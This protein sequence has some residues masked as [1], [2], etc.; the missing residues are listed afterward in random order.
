MGWQ[1]LTIKTVRSLYE[2]SIE[3]NPWLP[4][5]VL[6]QELRPTSQHGR[7]RADPHGRTSVQVQALQRGVPAADEEEP[8][9]ADLQ[10]QGHRLQQY[11]LGCHPCTIDTLL[12]ELWDCFSYEAVLNLANRTVGC[13]HN[14]LPT[15]HGPFKLPHCWRCP[16]LSF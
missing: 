15:E 5:Q 7:P 9:R 12:K 1:N 13:L 16:I 4:F 6:R 8:A 14:A 11:Y 10:A 3:S 2:R